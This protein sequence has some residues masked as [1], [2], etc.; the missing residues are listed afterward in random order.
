[1]PQHIS[2][3]Q[4]IQACVKWDERTV[5]L[6]DNRVTAHTAISEYDTSDNKEGLRRGFHIITMADAP[7]GI[8]GLRLEWD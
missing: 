2:Q 3:S 4:D 1:M 8:D 7:V 5:A 6:W